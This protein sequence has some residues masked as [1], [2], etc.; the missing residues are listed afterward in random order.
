MRESGPRASQM[1][2]FH[3]R[4]PPGYRSDHKSNELVQLMV[5]DKVR[6]LRGETVFRVAK[7]VK[8]YGYYLETPDGQPVE[9]LYTRN[10]LTKAQKGKAK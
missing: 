9:G 2:F 1:L 3:R 10:V 8:G 4:R 5:G 7:V 6:I